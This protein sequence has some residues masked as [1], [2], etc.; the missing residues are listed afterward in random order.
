MVSVFDRLKR[1]LAEYASPDDDSVKL[2]RQVRC[3]D[4]DEEMGN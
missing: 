3:P 1:L 2:V 4:E